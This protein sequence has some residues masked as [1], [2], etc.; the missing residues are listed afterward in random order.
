MRAAERML[1]EVR[2]EIVAGAT[3]FF[4]EPGTL[5]QVA[6]LTRDWFRAHL[7]TAV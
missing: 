7:V 4:E 5:A 1:T 2:L 3:H 6:Q